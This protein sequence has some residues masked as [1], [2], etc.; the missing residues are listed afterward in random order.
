MKHNIGVYLI[1]TESEA[2][3]RDL[4]VLEATGHISYQVLIVQVVVLVKILLEALLV[5]I[6]HR[7][8]PRH[9]LREL[10][11]AFKGSRA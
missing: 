3:S 4:P 6:E 11:L 10:V 5:G 2:V 9:C 8:L 7:L 1:N